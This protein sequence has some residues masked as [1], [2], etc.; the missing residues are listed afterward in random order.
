M[1]NCTLV[2]LKSIV[3]LT[4]ISVDFG[5]Y[6]KWQKKKKDAAGTGKINE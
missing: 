6:P 2:K 1:G 4:A 3:R 5:S